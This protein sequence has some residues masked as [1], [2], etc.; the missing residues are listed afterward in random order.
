MKTEPT[1]AT[2]S[3]NGDSLPSPSSTT[4]PETV[5]AVLR[6]SVIVTNPQGLH[7]RPASSF[8]KLARQFK[9]QI[10]IRRDDRIVNGKSQVEIILLA[11]EPGTE[12]VIEVDGP[13]ADVAL[14]LLAELLARPSSD[15]DDQNDETK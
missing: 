11:A 2:A 7:L 9:S 1:I 13:D 3:I 14:P 10:S 12:L 5:V 8:A 15:D 6:R 4:L